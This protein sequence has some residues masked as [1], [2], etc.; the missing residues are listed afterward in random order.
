MFHDITERKQAEMA[1]Q[2]T[3]RRLQRQSQALLEL[4]KQRPLLRENLPAAVQLFTQIAAHTLEVERSSIWL[5]NEKRSRLRC[6]NLYERSTDTHQSGMTLSACDCP[7]YFQALQDE[8]MIAVSD[9]CRD[10][11]TQELAATY[12]TPFQIASW[13]DAPI[14]RDGKLVGIVC[15]E[16]LNSRR[17]WT[18]EEE[19]FAGSLADFVSLAMEELERLQ[20]Q[21]DLQEANKHLEQRVAERTAQLAAS[22]KAAETARLKAETANRTKSEFLARMSHELRTPLN[23]ILGF[24]QLLLREPLTA[25]QQEQLR[26]INRS[27]EHLLQLINDVL[28]MSKIEAGRATLNC[29]SFDLHRLLSSLEEMLKLKAAAKR[30]QLICDCSTQ[31]PRYVYTDEGKLQQV[32]INL[33][34]NAIKFTATGGVTLR[35][36]VGPQDSEDET[37]CTIVF[38]VED[39]GPGIAVEELDTLFEAFVQTTTG[40]QSQTGTGLGLSISQK[41]AQL[42]GGNM[43]V[44]STL[45]K[46]SIFRCRVPVR[47]AQA[48]DLVKTQQ[49]QRRPIRLAANQPQYRLLVVEDR[50]ENRKLLVKLLTALGFAVRQAK[51]GQEGIALWESWNPHLILMD[52]CMPVMNGYEAAKQIKAHPQGQAT[53]ILALTASA[54]EEERNAILAAGCDDFIRKPFR[55][56]ILLNCIAEHLKVRYDYK[57]EASDEPLPLPVLAPDAL[58]TMSAD[59]VA[60]LRNAATQVDAELV[61][62]LIQEIPEENAQLIGGLNHLVSQFR[63]DQIVSLTASSPSRAVV[64][65]Q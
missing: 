42:M 16:H 20:A 49:S 35:V 31:V 1:L 58:Q 56:E 4:T 57:D 47:L 48:D 12:L 38:E 37:S 2:E 60:Q 61:T 62:A 63:F 44:D 29:N 65:N 52:M 34:S 10:R 64:I 21:S 27:G 19:H 43:S 22:T 8:R 17:Q 14:R 24:T 46:G 40:R 23:A 26:I 18:L 25:P 41:F 36:G 32:L 5:Y 45:G 3:N 55:E 7:A 59:W 51:N 28:E 9:V 11:R 30:L 33:L 50:W 15:N 13:L 39:T 6:L 54:F 53:T